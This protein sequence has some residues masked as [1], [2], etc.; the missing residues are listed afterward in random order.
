MSDIDHIIETALT[1]QRDGRL[2]EAADIYRKVLEIDPVHADAIHFLGMIAYAQKNY[3]EA[4]ELIGKAILVNPSA[5]D[6]HI[7]IASVFLATGNAK[8]AKSHALTH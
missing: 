8:Q 5:A 2:E 6:F 1:H 3:D 7:N 4:I